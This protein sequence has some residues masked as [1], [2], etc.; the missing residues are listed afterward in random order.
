MAT[1]ASSLG[2]QAVDPI[3]GRDGLAGLHI[4]SQ[5]GPVA[6][7]LDLFVGNGA[8]HTSTKGSSLP[9]S[10][11]YQRL[12]E[13]VAVFIGQDWI[14]QVDFGEPGMAPRMT[15]SM[16]GWVAAVIGYGIAVAA[17]TGGDPKDVNFGNG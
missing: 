5:R 10:A 17:Q 2:S 4:G 1:T 11:R 12:H 14:V 13:I 9:S 15:S 3:R 8:F 16:L 7:F 6:F